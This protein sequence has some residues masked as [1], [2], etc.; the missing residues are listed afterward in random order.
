MEKR[1][2][3]NCNISFANVDGEGLLLNLDL[4]GI[5]ASSGSACASGSLNPS[6]VL[7]AIGVPS[8]LAQSSLRVTI[9]KYNTQEEVDYLLDNLEKIIKRIRNIK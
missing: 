3:G 1:L 9:G 2:P 8:Q 5:C 7:M 4:K 6:H